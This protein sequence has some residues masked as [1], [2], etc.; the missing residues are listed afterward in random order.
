M[1]V[2]RFPCCIASPYISLS[3][4]GFRMLETRADPG[5]EFRRRSQVAR[6]SER[7]HNVALLIDRD[8]NWSVICGRGTL[9]CFGF[10][11]PRLWLGLPSLTLSIAALFLAV[12]LLPA[13][14]L[15]I[16][17]L[18]YYSLLLAEDFITLTHEDM[19]LNFF[20]IHE[21]YFISHEMRIHF[22]KKNTFI[23]D[24]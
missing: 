23:I 22:W 8:L 18:E 13:L 11:S 21:L 19:K 14:A 9:E 12:F 7:P 10:Y 1:I 24:K 5:A 4:R 6:G 17:M 2:F 20:P 16:S 15:L 3:S